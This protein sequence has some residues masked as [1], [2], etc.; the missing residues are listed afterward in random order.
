[1]RGCMHIPRLKG[2]NMSTN[3]KH[4]LLVGKMIN[5][6]GALVDYIDDI[7]F[8]RHLANLIRE[9]NISQKEL[10][11][12][13]GVK[14]PIISGILH[15]HRTCGFK[16]ATRLANGFELEGEERERLIAKSKQPLWQENDAQDTQ[17]VD[18]RTDLLNILLN[19]LQSNRVDIKEIASITPLDPKL[20][21]RNASIV[22]KT[23]ETIEFSLSIRRQSMEPIP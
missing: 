22:M 16:V 7:P 4:N 19:A 1:M 20:A 18:F 11:R 5:D 12:K 6:D 21:R 9:K 15:G 23:G 14:E 13:S 2:K 3:D 10:A 17:K 8:R